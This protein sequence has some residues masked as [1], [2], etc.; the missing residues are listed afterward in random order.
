MIG[1][2]WRYWTYGALLAAAAAAHFGLDEGGDGAGGGVA[3]EERNQIALPPLHALN[4]AGQSAVKRNIF[5]LAFKPAPAAVAVEETRK[6]PPPPV[7]RLAE[8]EVLGVVRQRGQRAILIKAGS[9][10]FTIV[11]GQRFGRD[12][13]LEIDMVKSGQ[14]RV[15]DRVAN[16]S[17]T[18]TLSDE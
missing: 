6:P 11:A 14:I 12:D 13:A 16:V 1:S 15:S 17:K 3:G 7:D 2:R 18:F 8:V 10:V 5:A 9:D 4:A